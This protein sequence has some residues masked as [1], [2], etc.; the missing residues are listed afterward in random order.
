LVIGSRYRLIERL[1]FGALGEVWRGLDQT[2]G[3]D[4][5]IKLLPRFTAG[6]LYEEYAA[7]LD[8]LRRNH[9]EAVLAKATLPIEFQRTD[10]FIYEIL[11]LLEN[12]RSLAYLLR[13]Q[14]PMGLGHAMRL[15]AGTAEA[16]A[17][18][19]SASIVHGDLKPSNILVAG[20]VNLDVR[21]IDF[22]MFKQA[23]YGGFDEVIATYRYLPPRIRS[24]L[25]PSETLEDLKDHGETRVASLKHS[26]KIGPYIDVYALGVIA[27]EMLVGRQFTDIPTRE[28]EVRKLLEQR[29]T[30]F[31]REPEP[32]RQTL[33]DLVCSMLAIGK[34]VPPTAEAVA[35]AAH[36][37]AGPAQAMQSM[38][39]G[40]QA[41]AAKAT[42]EALISELLRA[43]A[44]L[45]ER[46][47]LFVRGRDVSPSVTLNSDQERL[48]AGIE[49][50]F[51]SAKSRTQ[52]S[53]RLG[54]IMTVATFLVIM[55]M[56]TVAITMSI[57]TGKAA[58]G[59]VFGGAGV[60]T[61]IGTL[62]WRPYDRL[63][64]ATILA[65]E[66]EIIHLKVMTGLGAAHASDE[67]ARI[68]QEAVD[69]LRI[70]FKEHREP[71][72]KRSPRKKSS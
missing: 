64:G 69:A 11:P 20:D 14:Q 54:I 3:E 39:Q 53:W 57:V 26:V 6:H 8:G 12:F 41:D 35:S 70:I 42:S 66:I 49:T 58:W 24:A 17:N 33:I 55:V 38:G 19:H 10:D 59:I 60:S 27:L 50:V 48:V 46:T 37:L 34:R 18:L 45:L 4:V 29:A 22:G 23:P 5:A 1:G 44:E 47:Q 63:F 67:K 25:A 36:A 28:A 51:A 43:N 52:T 21:L 13:D 31:A 62:I 32:K 68:C 30:A 71:Q 61:I 16:L 15:L 40:R 2:T 65:Q 9:S 72:S 56:I 7:Y